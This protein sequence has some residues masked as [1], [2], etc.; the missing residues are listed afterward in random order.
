MQIL[1]VIED[2]LV[3]LA[4][5]ERDGPFCLQGFNSFLS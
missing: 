2:E 1:R 3:E 4:I 5:V